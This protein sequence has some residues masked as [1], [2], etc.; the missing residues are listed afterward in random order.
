[1]ARIREAGTSGRSDYQLD[2]PSTRQLPP[3]LRRAK[4]YASFFYSLNGR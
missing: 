3:A 1:M 4:I 2:T